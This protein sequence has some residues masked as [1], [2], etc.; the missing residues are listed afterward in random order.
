M[1]RFNLKRILYLTRILYEV[2]INYFSKEELYYIVENANWSIKE[3]GLSIKKYIDRKFR[4]TITHFG[5]RNA[6]VHYGSINTFLS[7]A[8]K[9]P[10]KSN[11]I[12]VTWFHVVPG[13]KR[14]SLIP[15]VVDKVD[16]WHT[17]ALKTKNMLI[18]YGVPSHKIVVIPLGVDFDDF[19]PVTEKER[20]EIRESFGIKEN[21]LVIGSFQKDGNGWDE[22]NT[23]KLIKGPDIFCDVIE[24][25][26]FRYQLF[27]LLT[28]PARGY[29][30]NRLDKAN[31]SYRH[32]FLDDPRDVAN[33]FR[34]TDLYLVTSR[35]EGG[36]KSILE[37]M[38]CGVPLVSTDV[39]MAPEMMID[40]ENGFLVEVGDTSSIYQ[41][42]CTLIDDEAKRN[43]FVFNAR[44]TV[45]S[46]SWEH[47][48][49]RY[50][51]E[52]Y[53]KLI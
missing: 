2:I 13:D 30:K 52:I 50:N 53:K 5:V 31:I 35:E 39:G 32:D 10:H 7:K 49:I 24:K 38:A 1:S 28:G 3:D 43:T 34:A 29:V 8:P 14:I 18:R 22:G 15:E 36:P 4:V 37:S 26:S 20:L 17:S 16:L 9:L 21:M 45:K 23:P 44:E 27:I 11:K 33:Y 48:V 12:V 6:I 40:G 46:F 19:S 25:L 41:K 51:E 42:A 47:T